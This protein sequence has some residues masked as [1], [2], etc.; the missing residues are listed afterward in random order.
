MSTHSL[1]LSVFTNLLVQNALQALLLILLLGFTDARSF[2]RPA[3]LPLT[4]VFIHLALLP[5][6]DASSSERSRALASLAAGN[7]FG[8]V[9]TYVEAVLLNRWSFA[10]GRCPIS[11]DG[12]MSVTQ[13]PPVRD[14]SWDRWR[15]PLVPQWDMHSGRWDVHRY[16]SDIK[17]RFKFGLWITL[18]YRFP[19]TPWQVARIPNF[20]PSDPAWRPSRRAFLTAH[21]R[22]FLVCFFVLDV[23]GQGFGAEEAATRFA[24]DKVPLLTR[25]RDVG[26]E[27]LVTR[28]GTT[29]FS[30]FTIACM[31]QLFYSCFALV[32]VR[33]Q[34][35]S[36]AAFEIGPQGIEAW[37]P[38]FGRL[39]DCWSVRH[40]WG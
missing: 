9:L 3:A 38:M 19:G 34:L 25:W 28:V 30:W 2:L 4:L 15:T 13:V 10:D 6:K 20:D 39:A 16:L 8:F 12:G 32:A 14:T 36:V 21:L 31:V 17:T 29:L 40:F 5:P 37:P 27:E 18:S 33:I 26:A 24:A 22:T 23:A 11:T 35:K 7:T 1:M